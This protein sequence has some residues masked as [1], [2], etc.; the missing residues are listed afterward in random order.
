MESGLKKPILNA[1]DTTPKMSTRVENGV[2]KQ[3]ESDIQVAVRRHNSIS[4][5]P[6]TTPKTSTPKVEKG[7]KKQ[8]ESDIQVAVRRHNSLLGSLVRL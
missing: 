5:A 8:V 4:N 3:V 2:K 1:P 7:L 6:D